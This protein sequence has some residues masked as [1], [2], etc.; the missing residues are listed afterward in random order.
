[1]EPQINPIE[2][3]CN[4]QAA[5]W[6]KTNIPFDKILHI[7]WHEDNHFCT[8]TIDNQTEFYTPSVIFTI[9]LHIG[10]MIGGY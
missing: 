7:V 2:I 3:T 4:A 9:G 6:L 5:E 8:F 10:R 1:M